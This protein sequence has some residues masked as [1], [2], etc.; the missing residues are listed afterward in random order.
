VSRSFGT[1]HSAPGISEDLVFPL[2]GKEFPESADELAVA[3]RDALAQVLTLPKMDGAVTVEGK[4]PSIRKLKVNL[5]NAEV[6]ATEPPPKPQPTG[7]RQKG[8]EV[9]QLEVSGKPIK[10]E[11]NR[12]ELELKASGVTLDFARDKKGQPLLVLADAKDGHVQAR[13]SKADIESLAR[14]AAELAARG[15]G[16]KIDGLDLTLTGDGKRSLAADVRVKAKKMMVSGVIHITGHVDVDDEMNATV[17]KLD[18]DGEG[19]IGA[20]ASGLVKSKLKPYEGQ[21]FPL[22]TFSLGDVSLRDL[23]IDVK[24][25]VQVSAEF[26]SK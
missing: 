4:F 9:E 7:K 5:N 1:W 2:A 22:M 15:Q 26:G 24:N 18:C 19:M 14:A 16:I 10:Y 12:L 23:K 13:M 25:N 21:T 8:I 11:K 20:M 6:S 17:S 3:I